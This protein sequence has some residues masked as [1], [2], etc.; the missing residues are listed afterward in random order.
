MHTHSL[1]LVPLLILEKDGP[2][3]LSSLDGCWL[4]TGPGGQSRDRRQA[5]TEGEKHV[6]R[7]K[8]K[9]NREERKDEVE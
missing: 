1:R 2:P 4:L 8:K 7:E 3:R 9:K 6:K 5:V